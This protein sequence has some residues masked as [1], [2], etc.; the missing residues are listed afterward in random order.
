MENVN[1]GGRRQKKCRMAFKWKRQ[2]MKK[3]Q[4]IENFKKQKQK[5]RE[6]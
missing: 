5:N 1:E 3:L 6:N 2:G 4:I